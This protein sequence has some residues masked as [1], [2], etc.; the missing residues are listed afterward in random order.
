MSSA[1]SMMC[2]LHG[3]FEIRLVRDLRAGQFGVERVQL[4]EVAVLAVRRTGADVSGLP[5]AVDA[6][7]AGAFGEPLA[8]GW[9]VPHQPVIEYAGRHQILRHVGIVD[10]QHQT[11]GLGRDELNASG[12]VTLWPS[13][14]IF[15]RNRRRWE[16]MRCW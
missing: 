14:V 1:C 2:A 10:D 12:G 16:E 5:H 9:K 15:G 4:E 13:Q 3:A 8:V 11:L 6:A 7:L